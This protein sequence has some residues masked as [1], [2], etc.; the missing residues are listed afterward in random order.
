MTVGYPYYGRAKCVV[1][2][3]FVFKEFGKNITFT[4]ILL[5]LILLGNAISENPGPFDNEISISI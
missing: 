1:C 3:K 4:L 2:Y 5:M